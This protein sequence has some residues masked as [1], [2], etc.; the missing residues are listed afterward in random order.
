MFLLPVG[1]RAQHV[2]AG[3]ESQVAQLMRDDARF[4]DAVRLAPRKQGT[5]LTSV[6]GRA[7]G[8]GQSG[9]KS[10]ETG[11]GLVADGVDVA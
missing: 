6:C 1:W 4:V 8:D 3:L 10:A 2:T 9:G 11:D 5:P 7:L